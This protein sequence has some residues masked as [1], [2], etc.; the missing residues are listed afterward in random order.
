MINKQYFTNL[1]PDLDISDEE[2]SNLLVLL[3]SEKENLDLFLSYVVE[4][5]QLIRSGECKSLIEFIRCIKFIS[6]LNNGYDLLDSYINSH[7]DQKIVQDY[8]INKDSKIKNKLKTLSTLYSKS[9]LVLQI[10]NSMDYPLHLLFNGYRYQA[11]E[12]LRKE[13]L[14]APLP[15]DRITAADK[16]LVHLNP[17]LNN[18]NIVNINLGTQEK[19]TIDK[20][21]EAL[22]F[23]AKEKIKLLESNN[24]ELDEIINVKI[25]DE[26]RTD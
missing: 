17:T 14:H 16:L 18:P 7:S 9:K 1:F 3:D 2:Y 10:Q 20:Y 12:T 11:I 26:S 24:F 19:S 5:R 8:F 4:H 22:D 15:K 21:S 23:L 25:V 13:M 6:Y